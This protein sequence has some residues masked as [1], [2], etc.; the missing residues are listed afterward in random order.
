MG[1]PFASRD[2]LGAR[3]AELARKLEQPTPANVETVRQELSR[4]ATG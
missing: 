2:R 1:Q 3:L 4:L